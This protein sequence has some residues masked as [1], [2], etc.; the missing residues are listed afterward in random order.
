MKVLN[1]HPSKINKILAKV[2]LVALYLVIS[3]SS[4]RGRR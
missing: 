4:V 1:L 3:I 2:T